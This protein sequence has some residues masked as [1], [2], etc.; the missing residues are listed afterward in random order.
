MKALGGALG[1]C[2]VL[3]VLSP[4]AARANPIGIG[5]GETARAVRAQLTAAV[6]ND[7]DSMTTLAGESLRANGPFGTDK[8][9]EVLVDDH[10]ASAGIRLEELGVPPVFVFR[11]DGRDGIERNQGHHE[12][13][14]PSAMRF[15]NPG[16]SSV[17]VTTPAAGS[18]LP[19]ADPPLSETIGAAISAIPEPAPL[20]LVMTGI[21]VLL[22]YRC[23]VG[24]RE[25][26]NSGT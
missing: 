9:M 3:A 16:D 14:G 10:A 25:P 12:H 18:L 26:W 8:S 2:G 5:A 22:L 15:V 21:A 19:T 6:P 13:G 17:V 7:V 4:S 23:R 20:P 11:Q 24:T 1:V